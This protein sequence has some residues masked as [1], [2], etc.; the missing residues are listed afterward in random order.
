MNRK[1]M[2]P[3]MGSLH[4]AIYF[5]NTLFW[6]LLIFIVAIPKALVPIIYGEICAPDLKYVCGKLDLDQ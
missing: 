2:A 3:I 4:L 1:L 5:F 6:S